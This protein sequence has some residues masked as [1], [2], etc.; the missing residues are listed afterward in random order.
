[1]LRFL[2]LAEIAIFMDWAFGSVGHL[3]EP[4]N[5]F[6]K[7]SMLGVKLLEIKIELARPH[8]D[9]F[10]TFIIN[11]HLNKNKFSIRFGSGPNNPCDNLLVTN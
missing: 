9:R 10:F 1:L 2:A 8:L 5:I 7:I 6:Y 3:K 4:K 11:Y